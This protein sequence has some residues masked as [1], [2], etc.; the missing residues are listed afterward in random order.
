MRYALIENDI[1]S[2]I[3]WLYSGNNHKFPNAV[4]IEELPVSIGDEYINGSFYHNGEKLLTSNE[5]EWQYYL[6]YTE[7]VQ[8]A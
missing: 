3:I 4:H 7:G 5:K 6:S 2:N 8:E 1:V